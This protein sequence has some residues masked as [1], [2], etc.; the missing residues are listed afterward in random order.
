MLYRKAFF[1]AMAAVPSFVL[2][3]SSQAAPIAPLPPAATTDAGTLTPVYYY[4]HHLGY[5]PHRY[6]H[7][8]YRYY[9][10]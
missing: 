6:Y 1:A 8:R 2:S 4:R 10:Y 9:R 3:G 5:Y 7:P